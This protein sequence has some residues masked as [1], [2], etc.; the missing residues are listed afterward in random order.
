MER[1]Y[2]LAKKHKVLYEWKINAISTYL[3]APVTEDGLVLK[4]P[5]F[6]VGT[7][8][9]DNWY[10]SLN[11]KKSKLCVC[12]NFISIFLYNC[13]ENEITTDAVFFILNNDTERVFIRD[14]K[15]VYKSQLG[16]G[17]EEFLEK[18]RLQK[19]KF[20]L[21]PHDILTVGV[22][23]TV[24]DECTTITTSVPFKDIKSQMSHDYEELYNSK[25]GSDVVVEVGDKEFPAHKIILIARS[26]V[27]AA[28]FSHEMIEKKDNRLTIIDI[29]PEIFEKVLE[30]IYTDKVVDLDDDAND[31]LEAADK[32]QLETLKQMC[33][34]SLSKSL[35][36][37]NSIYLM[38]L[39][40]RHNAKELLEYVSEF[41][42]VNAE[43]IIE[44]KN[45]KEWEKSKSSLDLMLFKKFTML[46]LDKNK[47]KIT[48][49]S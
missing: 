18:E 48:H 19:E 34:N 40:E 25:I 26:P 37:E 1:G 32:Y 21:I 5:E 49:L 9:N 14:F 45:F 10:I 38:T 23:V 4:S 43:E 2:S 33:Q 11:F 12:P 29:D 8:I 22:E 41:M 27:L 46:N 6:S 30:Y 44:T 7:E 20:E 16:W 15:K 3:N 39:A 47:T 13:T 31:L 35:T 36:A 17:F 42:V 28:M 24:Y